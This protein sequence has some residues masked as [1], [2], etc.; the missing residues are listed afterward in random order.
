ME[1]SRGGYG[2]YRGN[3]R[4]HRGG[5]GDGREVKISKTLS[6]ILRHGALELGLNMRSDGYVLVSELL[7]VQRCKCK[8]HQL[9]T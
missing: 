9:L 3:Q 5:G 6:W 4:G 7:T 8:L 2:G 1:S